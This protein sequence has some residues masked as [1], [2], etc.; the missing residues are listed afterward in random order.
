MFFCMAIL[1][2][3]NASD[4]EIHVGKTAAIIPKQD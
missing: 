2:R 4:S 1:G 3:K